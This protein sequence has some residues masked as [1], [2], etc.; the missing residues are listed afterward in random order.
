MKYL[1]YKK[2]ARS[3]IPYSVETAKQPGERDGVSRMHYGN[4]S[5]LYLRN[6]NFSDFS[7]CPV[8]YMII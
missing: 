4:V 8:K 3:P 6:S 1:L 5:I 7:S 2:L